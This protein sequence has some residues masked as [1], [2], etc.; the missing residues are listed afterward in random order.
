MSD[1]KLVLSD[2]QV[3]LTLTS[4]DVSVVISGFLSKTSVTMRFFNQTEMDSEGELTFPMAEGA[5]LSG[6][7]V[8]INGVLIDGTVIEK[9]KA[10]ETFE[11]EARDLVN[12]PQV[13]IAE[14]VVGN[15]FKT[16]IT[17]LRKNQERIVK[18]AFIQDLAV[19]QSS[20]LYH[21]PL[22]LQNVSVKPSLSGEC[23]CYQYW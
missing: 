14:N 8:D 11:S 16:R 21:L 18:V 9:E 4:V 19:S 12:K 13:S 5:V 1:Y 17:P 7:A 2:G 10:R 15:V 20:A 6:Y 3:E 23:I 22:K